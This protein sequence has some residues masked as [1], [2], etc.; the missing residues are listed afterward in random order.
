MYVVVVNAVFAVPLWIWLQRFKI[1]P[2]SNSVAPCAMSRSYVFVGK[3]SYYT[4]PL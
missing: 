3:K 4:I 1:F 2:S